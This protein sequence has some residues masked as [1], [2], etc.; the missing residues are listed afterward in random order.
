MYNSWRM[1]IVL[2]L[3]S[4]AACFAPAPARAQESAGDLLARGR[5]FGVMG[6][7][8]RAVKRDAAGKY[9]VLVSL[10]A[11]RGGAAA[12]SAVWIFDLTGKQV[13]QVPPAAAQNQP[14][15][16]LVYGEDF[17]VDAA[18]RL[19]IADRGAN[20]LRVFQPDG[21][22][23]LS[24]P[25]EIPSSIVALPAREIAATNMKS[26]RLVTVFLGPESPGGP[27]TVPGKPAAAGKL[28]REFGDPTDLTERRETNR[29]ANGGRLATDAAGHIYYAFTYL[30][31]PTV[32]KYDHAGYA[33]QEI[34]V[35]TLEF[36]A[37]AQAARRELGRQSRSS[38]PALKTVIT[39]VGV[40]PAS[41]QV[42]VAMGN[43]LLLFDRDGNRRG[44]YRTYTPDGARLE[45]HA[46]LVEPA[47][48]LLA[49][50]PLGVYD[51]ARPDKR[52]P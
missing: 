32:R 13:G 26:D 16:A 30:P 34:V 18:G 22:L 7:G 6:P 42:W 29:F 31:E 48:L 9:Y 14:A 10:S 50:D 45:I 11:A 24:I 5:A 37:T 33:N 23:A 36:M 17:D 12:S 27:A 8:V 46:I 40:D 4:L 39:A 38:T 1:R 25:F 2:A 52:Q 19:Y 28:V 47:R 49:N 44:T 51:F 43:I 20:A 35:S 15:P 41:E 3:V 21:T